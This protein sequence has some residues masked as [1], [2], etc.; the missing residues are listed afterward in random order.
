MLNTL[1]VFVA[2]TLPADTPEHLTREHV[3]AVIERT[4]LTTVEISAR[5]SDGYTRTTS[6]GAGSIISSKGVVLTCLHV[7]KGFPAIKVTTHDGEVHSA[8]LIFTDDDLDLAILKFVSD[9][10][11]HGIPMGPKDSIV[12]GES[13]IFAGYPQR[14]RRQMVHAKLEGNTSLVRVPAITAGTKMLRFEG[15]VDTGFSGGPVVSLEGRLVGLVAAR[16]TKHAGYG[17]AIPARLVF[18]SLRGKGAAQDHGV[19]RVS[20]KLK[21]DADIASYLIE[22][23]RDLAIPPPPPVL[24]GRE[25]LTRN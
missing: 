9:G 8:E 21:D 1:A 5:R 19:A 25:S 2:L 22:E 7:V 6:Y 18:D 11:Y 14:G 16:S 12:P 24:A 4:R 20:A 10:K 3:R 23:R 15:V 13:A 17:Y